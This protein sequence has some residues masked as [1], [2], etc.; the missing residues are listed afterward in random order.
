MR[1]DYIGLGL[2]AV[3]LGFL[4]VMLD[5]GQTDDW[6]GSNFIVVCTVLT[7]VGLVGAVI[8]ELHT[9]DPV[10]DL[11][12]LK[13]RNFLISTLSM[14]MLGVVLY[15][16][17]VLL[18]IFLQT[19]LGYNATLS[20]LVLSPGGIAVM[21]MMPIVGVLIGKIQARWLV[22]VGVLITSLSLFPH[23]AISILQIDFQT[24]MWAR[25]YQSLGMAF[26]FV[27]INTM[28]FYFIAKEKTNNATG[29][30][31]LARNVG[32]SV[33]IS[34]VAT[35]LSRGAQ[36]HQAYL[37]GHVN[38][39]DPAY[40]AQL[41]GLISTLMTKGMSLTAATAQAQGMIY[42]MVQRQASML[43][44][45]D[46]FRLLGACDADHYSAAVFDEEERRRKKEGRSI[47]H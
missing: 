5:K 7:V 2:L 46:N 23:V 24:A 36:V 27:P 10:V 9:P 25:I 29:I 40:R 15:G 4:Q 19:L 37:T 18:P 26:L 6:F 33:G 32:G 17:T 31:N 8:W 3:G 47:G 45:V 34:L 1:I 28:A 35:M 14:F 22:I 44:F 11:R 41:A 43:A 39:L 16:T 12:L 38:P 42:G 20:G 13:D 21:V 30:I